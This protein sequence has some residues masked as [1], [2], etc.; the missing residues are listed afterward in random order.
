MVKL[1]FL[2]RSLKYS[3]PDTKI[4]AYKSLIQPILEYGNIVWDPYTN[5]N[6]HKL[7]RI[8]NKAAR[9]IFNRYGPASV[10][11]LVAKAGLKRISEKNK[12]SRLLFFFKIIKGQLKS[13]TAEYLELSSGYS[14][15]QRHR[16]TVLPFQPKNNVFKYSFFPCTVKEWNEL[17]NIIVEATDIKKF[18]KAISN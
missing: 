9:F 8:Q 6:T 4:L 17:D 3:A 7:E 12:I 1:H 16:F 18:E 11:E 10:S 13:T 5:V 2:K 15:R 14:T